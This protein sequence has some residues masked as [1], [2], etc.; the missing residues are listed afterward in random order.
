MASSRLKSKVPRSPK[1]RLVDEAEEINF[2]DIWRILST[3]RVLVFSFVLI[4]FFTALFYAFYWP[5]TYEAVTTLKVSM[6]VEVIESEHIARNMIKELRLA[7]QGE[8]KGLGERDLVKR[9]IRTVLFKNDKEVNLLTIQVRAH[10]PQ[11]AADLANA[12]AQN[13]IKVNLEVSQEPA[14][15][16]YNF[17]QAQL[18]EMERE[19]KTKLPNEM[20]DQ[21]SIEP[22]SDKLIYNSLLMQ[23]QDVLASTESADPYITV[24]NAAVVPEKPIEPKMLRASIFG[25]IFG[26]FI[27]VLSGFGLECGKKPKS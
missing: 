5:K 11:L 24:V 26:L 8:F 7:D 6:P 4:G 27:G 22:Q 12:W 18:K 10:N 25:S 9:L 3:Y 14:M 15:V 20:T 19:L 17:L 16:K 23:N 21:S 2:S 13:F 1:N